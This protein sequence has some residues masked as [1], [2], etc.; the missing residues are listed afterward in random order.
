MGLKALER[1]DKGLTELQ[2]RYLDIVINEY[3]GYVPHGEK[4]KI[5]DRLGC[6]LPYLSSLDTGQHPR[7]L[8]EKRK[9]IREV[10]P[11]AD[12]LMQLSQLQSLYDSAITAR[13]RA[14]MPL[15]DRDPVDIIDVARK[16]SQ[17]SATKKMEA[18]QNISS[19][20][21]NFSE[22][23]AE[24]LSQAIE[25]IERVLRGGDLG[26]LEDVLDGKYEIVDERK[27]SERDSKESSS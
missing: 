7:F 4:S 5:A 14:A 9:R 19:T 25:L 12:D 1:R 3:A 8:K 17:G 27:P 6:S 21:F 18:T 23:D 22:M 2:E 20:T 13:E 16:V 24:S 15:T 11:M 26:Q 10:I